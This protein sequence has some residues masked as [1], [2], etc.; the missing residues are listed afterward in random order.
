MTQPYIRIG[1]RMV[2]GS[3]PAFLIAEV[4][5]AH[6]GSLGFAHAFVDLAREVGADAIK[7]QTHIA[8]AETTPLET[9]RVDFSYE[10]ASRYDYW[11]RME[12]TAEQWA[13]LA[14]HAK[15]A[16][17]IFLSSPFSLEAFEILAR[18]GMPAWKVASGEISNTPLLEAMA[19]TGKPILLSSGMS[20]LAMLETRATE[21]RSRGVPFG[22]F[23]CTTK[24]PTP[25]EEVGVNLLPILRDRLSCP[26][27]LSD[28]SGS[29][30]PSLAAMAQGAAM[31]E[32]H[33]AFHRRQF[34]PDTVASL[35]PEEFALLARARDAFHTL[36]SNP[37]DKNA[38]AQS[39]ADMRRLFGKSVALKQ[40]Q[41][42]GTVLTREMLTTKKPGTG[43]PPDAIESL[44]GQTL[45]RDVSANE[46]LA[47]SDFI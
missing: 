16:G 41:P 14:E 46:L 43:L 27:G 44:V 20:D 22:M 38:V 40:A 36:L 45:A 42:K 37:V 34:G 21:L 33:I 1:D 30:F 10:D 15:D 31:I 28:H 8:A 19:A 29:P 11:K 5:Q 35:V 26:V 24:Y 47:A 17:L 32:V 7:F 6:D 25:L 3:A 39:M 18:I 23:Q 13:G 9:F 12:F 4:A 2:G